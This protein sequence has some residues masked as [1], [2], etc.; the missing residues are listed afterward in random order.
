[1]L[2]NLGCLRL[3]FLSHILDKSDRLSYLRS[4]EPPYERVSILNI[5]NYIFNK[6]SNEVNDIVR[7]ILIV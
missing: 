5:W 6:L 2:T 4:N 1:M 7:K 3:I